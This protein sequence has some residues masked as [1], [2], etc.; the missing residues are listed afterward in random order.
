MARRKRGYRVLPMAWRA[1]EGYATGPWTLCEVVDAIEAL[2]PEGDPCGEGDPPSGG[3][4]SRHGA[5][6]RPTVHRR[7]DPH[8]RREVGGGVEGGSGAQ[9]E[10]AWAS[11]DG[12]HGGPRAPDRA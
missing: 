6:L 12:L 9:G 5:G 8:S 11:C 2:P 7:G 1:W 4:A 10:L 3:P